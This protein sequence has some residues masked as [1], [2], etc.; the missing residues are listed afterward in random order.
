MPICL[1]PLVEH[2]QTKGD[3]YFDPVYP[4]EN[5]NPSDMKKR[6]MKFLQDIYGDKTETNL[7]P[8]NH[9]PGLS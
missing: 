6:G 5:V 7:A 2:I 9:F 1:L 8:Y 3:E 4:R